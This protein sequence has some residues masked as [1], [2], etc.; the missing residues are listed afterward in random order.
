MRDNMWW[1]K[2][3]LI[4]RSP[5]MI[6]KRRKINNDSSN[7][8]FWNF[9]ERTRQWRKWINRIFFCSIFEIYIEFKGLFIVMSQ[10]HLSNNEFYIRCEYIDAFFKFYIWIVSIQLG[11]E[12]WSIRRRCREEKTNP[13]F[14]WKNLKTKKRLLSTT[15]K[16]PPRFSMRKTMMEGW[17]HLTSNKNSFFIRSINSYFVRDDF[18][19]N[20]HDRKEKKWF[21]SYD[22]RSFEKRQTFSVANCI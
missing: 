17:E 19:M 15:W 11:C 18:C 22:N 21:S 13:P 7:I 16:I 3:L 9:Y 5:Y 12:K 2:H 20:R 4:F 1:K 10:F 14:E 8:S 6:I